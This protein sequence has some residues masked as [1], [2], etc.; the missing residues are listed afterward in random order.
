[1]SLF[2]AEVSEKMAGFDGFAKAGGGIVVF[3]SRYLKDDRP[4]ES[5]DGKG[6]DNTPPVNVTFSRRQM[7][8][9]FAAIVGGVDH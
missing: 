9:P 5:A 6:F 7:V 1:M 2:P 4:C 3:P 8:V